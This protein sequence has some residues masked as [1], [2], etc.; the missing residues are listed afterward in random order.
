MCI[1]YTFFLSSS[2]L[3]SIFTHLV[4]FTVVSIDTARPPP[5]YLALT[6]PR[7][8]QINEEAFR[9]HFSFQ[10]LQVSSKY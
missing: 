7:T 9:L 1:R 3:S 6:H 2:S 4:N 8:K 10:S 5:L